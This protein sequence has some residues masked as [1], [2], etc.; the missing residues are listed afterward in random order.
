MPRLLTVAAIALAVVVLVSS[1]GVEASVPNSA[2]P[3]PRADALSLP[4]DATPLPA[5][6]VVAP[7]GASDP[8]LLTLTLASPRSVAFSEFLSAVENPR[9]PLYRHFLS[10]PE[11]VSEF[12]PSPSVSSAV[13]ATLSTYGGRSVTVFPDRSSVTVLLTPPEVRS[14]LGVQ[15]VEYG[16]AGAFPLYTAEGSVSLPAELRGLVTGVSG[17]SDRSDAGFTLHLAGSAPRPLPARS[18]VGSFVYNTTSGSDWFVGSDY[19]QLFGATQ[20]F[21]GAGSVPNATFPQKVA[22]ATLLAGGYNATT[23][24][25]LPPWDPAVVGTY[26]NETFP[27]SWP[28]PRVAGVPVTIGTVTPPPPGSFGGLNDSTLDEFE[29]SLDLE[30]AGSMAPGASVFN[31][32][33]PGSLLENPPFYSALADDFAQ[34]LSDALAYN[35]ST[36]RLAVVSGSFGL[37]DLN[38]SAWNQELLAAAATGVTVVAASGD[39]GN[40]PDQLTERDDGPWPVWPASAAFN[41][42]GTLSVGGVSLSVSGVPTAVY[43]GSGSLD[44]EYDSNITGV[45]SLSAWYDNGGS[46]P[47][48]GTEGGASVVF[49]EPSWQFHSAAQPAVVNATVLQGASTLGRTGPDV[50]LAGNNTIATVVANATG[51]VFFEVLEGTSVAAP[52]LAGLLADVVAVE[53]DRSRTGWAPLGFLDPEVYRIASYYAAHPSDPNDPF[54][55]VTVGHNYVFSAAPGWDATTG[56]GTVNA[57]RLLAVDEN[58]TVRGYVYTGP[59]PGLPPRSPGPTVPWTT[60]FLIFGVGIV[61]AVV[62]VALMARPSRVRQA[63]TVPYG[64][65]GGFGPGA[66]GGVYPGATFLCPYCGAVR[67]A[68]AGRCPQCGAF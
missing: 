37:P 14:L 68:E 16:H 50:A 31:F 41:G 32:Y 4:S 28:A 38:D 2:A 33:L 13:A 7:L 36:A 9:S 34:A 63:P 66:Q 25:N 1:L 42:S 53:S 56:W 15:L 19:T 62:L 55:D 39:Q 5:G 52:L 54:T 20:L 40:A 46:G 43:N 12:A 65:Q 60:I 51:G 30:M 64:A 47:V 10:Y 17:L 6:A 24:Q 49:P 44:L 8:V 22:I 59:T 57:T 29:N 61:A 11:Y 35:Y 48:A 23:A 27:T 21:P 3:S 67:P 18:S 45:T 58:A 26:F